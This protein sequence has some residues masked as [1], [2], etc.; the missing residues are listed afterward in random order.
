MRTGTNLPRVGDYN[1]AVVLDAVRRRS[2]VSRVELA[3]GTGLTSQTVSNVVR[4]LLDEGLVQET[5][6]APSQGGKPRTLLSL[7]ADAAYAVGIH[8]DPDSTVAVLLDLA[9]RVLRRRRL[10][11]TARSDPGRLAGTLGRTVNSLIK[12]AGVGRDR[13][14][15]VGVAVPG[16][17]DGGR[18]MVLDPPNLPDWHHVHLVDLLGRSTGLPVVMDNDATAAAIGERWAGG[19]ERSGSFL[20]VYV[21][22]GIGGG[23]MLADAVLRGDS[24]NAGE[25][26]HVLVEP[27]GNACH[28]GAHGCLEAYAAPYSVLAGFA[29]RHGFAGAERLGLTLTREETRTDWSRLCAAAAKDDACAVQEIRRAAEHIGHAALSTVNLLDVSRIV[30][31][32]E[33][34]RCIEEIVRAT[35]DTVVNGRSI[36]RAVRTV[37]V[38]SSLIGEAV[39]A[40]GAASL[41]LDGNYSPGWQMLLGEQLL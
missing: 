22:T 6:Q 20:F 12:K 2:P 34:L 23:I 1:R 7:R 4:R 38:E 33:S 16:P 10:S 30:L 39:G 26:G 14:L 24:G 36:A 21:G 8:L 27:G 5:G 25:F 9:G 17:I 31:S 15:G 18:G 29:E 19:A 35:V 37:S 32:G 40:V 3:E 11:T 28:C 41:V 13:V